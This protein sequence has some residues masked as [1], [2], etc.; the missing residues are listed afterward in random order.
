MIL[1]IAW[2]TQARHR[3]VVIYKGT[4]CEEGSDHTI[5]A[6]IIGQDRPTYKRRLTAHHANFSRPMPSRR[7][8]S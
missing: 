3:V 5:D 1:I 4:A 6:F 2:G 7:V 8:K